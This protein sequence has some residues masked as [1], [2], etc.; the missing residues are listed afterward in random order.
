M[1]WRG[2][3]GNK[4]FND[5]RANL[6]RFEN[7]GKANVLQ[8]AIPLGLF[9]SQY[10]SD[11]WLEN[12]SFLRFDN[13]TIGYRINTRNMKYVDAFRLSVTGNNLAVITKYTGIDPE[14]GGGYGGAGDNGIYPRTRNIAVGLNVIFK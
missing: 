14:L 1:L 7:L 6:S 10:G 3:G 9:T 8:S 2:A 5:L 11:L 13:L 12:G 4:I